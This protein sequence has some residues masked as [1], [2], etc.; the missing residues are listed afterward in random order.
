MPAPAQAP[1][2]SRPP[3]CP[4]EDAADEQAGCSL[5]LSP[6][7]DRPMP[8]TSNAATPRVP[9][10]REAG[11]SECTALLEDLAKAVAALDMQ[12]IRAPRATDQAAQDKVKCKRRSVSTLL[13]P[14]SQPQLI[15]L[16]SGP[17]P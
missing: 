10:T 17:W 6:P 3:N 8:G 7:T 13:R 2:I 1:D 5:A 9:A 11:V 16:F 12:D 15:Q 14:A 4:W